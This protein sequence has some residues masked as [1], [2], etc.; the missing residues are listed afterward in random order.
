MFASNSVKTPGP[1]KIVTYVIAGILTMLLGT[2]Y[3]YFL[4]LR[5]ERT[6]TDLY[7]LR[8]LN[9]M[10]YLHEVRLHEGFQA[11]LKEYAVYQRYDSF[12]RTVPDFLLGRWALFEQ[13]QRVGYHFISDECS[14]YLG[15]EDG[16]I[17]AVGKYRADY[18]ARYRIT[19]S[20]VEADIGDGKTMPIK[21]I[22][23][24]MDLHH[25]VVTLPGQDKPLYGYLCT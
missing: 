14:T 6:V 13:P 18:P 19:D 16:E 21:L 20:T 25:I 2:G 15:I 23:Y 8:Q 3:I 5:D 1:R 22:S 17:K 9:P 4:K 12:Q 24:G 7:Q 11:Y 10:R